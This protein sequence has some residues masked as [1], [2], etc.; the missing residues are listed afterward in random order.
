VTP[1]PPLNSLFASVSVLVET[2][3][4]WKRPIGQ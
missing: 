2:D 4:I 1:Y 3:Y